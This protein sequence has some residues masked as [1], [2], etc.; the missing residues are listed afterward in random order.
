MRWICGTPVL[1]VLS[2]AQTVAIAAS[3]LMIDRLKA[4]ITTAIG[5]EASWRCN[6]Q[7]FL[8]LPRQAY[9]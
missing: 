3:E 1:Q 7:H 5:V 4:R 9:S 2:G 8:Q 6:A